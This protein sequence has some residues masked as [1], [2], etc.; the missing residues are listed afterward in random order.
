MNDL[1]MENKTMTE[2]P[3]RPGDDECCGGGSCSPCVWD[4]YYE[5]LERWNEQNQ[6]ALSNQNSE[7]S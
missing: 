6:D 2:K 5:Q 3:E 4:Y 7:Q 1:L